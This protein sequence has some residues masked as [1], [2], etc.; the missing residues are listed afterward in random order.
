MSELYI[1]IGSLA[2]IL[3]LAGAAW[4]LRLGGGSIA[5][6]TEAMRAAEDQLSGFDADRALVG[7]DGQAALVH[8]RDGSVA[9]L[10]LHGTRIAVRRLDTPAIRQTSEGMVVASGERRFGEVLI[11]GVSAA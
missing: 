11:R 2:A 7:S 10:K 8:G 5:D 9:L 1:F 4:M 6:T 3:A